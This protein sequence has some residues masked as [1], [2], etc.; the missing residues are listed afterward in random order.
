M[1]GSTQRRWHG[2]WIAGAGL[3]CLGAASISVSG[4]TTPSTADLNAAS[5]KDQQVAKTAGASAE[6]RERLRKSPRR[7]ATRRR[8]R[9]T[10]KSSRLRGHLLK[11]RGLRKSPQRTCP[12][13]RES[14][15]W[16]TQP[17]LGSSRERPRP[18]PMIRSARP[19]KHVGR[20]PYWP[21]QPMSKILLRSG[22]VSRSPTQPLPRQ[23]GATLPNRVLLRSKLPA[24]RPRKLSPTTIP[25]SRRRGI[26]HCRRPQR[27][28]EG[29]PNRGAQCRRSRISISRRLPMPKR[30]RRVRADD[31]PPPCRPTD[32]TGSRTIS[33]RVS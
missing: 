24:N 18:S 1:S 4:C 20:K 14:P 27:R 15:T 23:N 29:R 19:R 17:K 7:R 12:A 32:G 30:P 13:R 25:E 11:R 21:R 9:K 5:K 26:A 2:G 6:R 33:Q 22:P 28:P 10:S 3:A 16:M 31:W 8:R